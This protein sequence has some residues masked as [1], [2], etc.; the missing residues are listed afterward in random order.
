MKYVVSLHGMR[1]S[2]PGHDEGARMHYELER[3]GLHAAPDHAI[4]L[5][6]RQMGQV[7][8]KRSGVPVWSRTHLG[9]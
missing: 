6:Q 2:I 9:V 8:V 1:Q 5:G 3:K 7:T 4:N